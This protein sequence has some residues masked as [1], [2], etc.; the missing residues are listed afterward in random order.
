MNRYSIAL[1]LPIH[2]ASF[3]CGDDG[4]GPSAASEVDASPTNEDAENTTT[5]EPSSP[6]SEPSSD[7][8]PTKREGPWGCYLQDHHVCDCSIESE[9]KCDGVGLWTEGCASC[10]PSTETPSEAS[11]GP[12]EAGVTVETS[13]S[14]DGGAVV[15]A[16]APQDQP[17][18]SANFGCYD[19]THH[20][21]ACDTT[22]AA[23]LA[24][25]GIWTDGCEC[26]PQVDPTTEPDASTESASTS[27][28]SASDECDSCIPVDAGP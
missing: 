25:E 16:S 23:C 2:L 10:A 28:P 14:R 3:A 15:D 22:E 1:L 6:T 9:A 17:D 11:S 26:G 8:S 7:D 20:T 13:T 21:C 19:P 24:D 5:G 18:A 4:S 12:T 27:E